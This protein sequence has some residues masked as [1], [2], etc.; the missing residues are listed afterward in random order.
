MIVTIRMAIKMRFFACTF[1]KTQKM[2]TLIELRNSYAIEW[3]EIVFEEGK[4]RRKSRRKKRIIIGTD[5]MKV[6]I[7]ALMMIMISLIYLMITF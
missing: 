5:I 7:V 1:R 6:M 3:V 2:M 4:R